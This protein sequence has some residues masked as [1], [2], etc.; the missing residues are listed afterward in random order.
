[1]PSDRRVALADRALAGDAAS[2]QTAA[3]L[4][5]L[6]AEEESSSDEV[7]LEKPDT[8]QKPNNKTKNKENLIDLLHPTL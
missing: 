8:R 2:Q 5:L 4:L 1:M 6:R 3:M 7:P